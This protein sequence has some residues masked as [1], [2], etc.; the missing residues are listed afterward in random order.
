MRALKIDPKIELDAV[1]ALRTLISI[2]P[3]VC[4][5]QRAAIY[6]AAKGEEREEFIGILAEISARIETMPKTYDQDGKGKDS[7]A[8][9]HYF[10]GAYDAY[11]TEK[12]MYADQRQAF[13]WANFGC[14]FE[15]GYISLA[16][17]TKNG[18]ELDLFFEPQR[19]KELGL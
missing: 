15:A 12:D 11:I 7:I 10:Q 1:F 6:E 8:Y 14:G 13:G 4:I 2:S 17:L 5:S 19:I 18:M 3:F 16:E 9:L